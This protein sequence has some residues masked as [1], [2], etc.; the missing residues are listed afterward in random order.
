MQDFNLS[1]WRQ[2]KIRNDKVITTSGTV[3]QASHACAGQHTTAMTAHCNCSAA[4]LQHGLSAS[5]YYGNLIKQI[6]SKPLEDT[7]Q[8][9]H[10]QVLQHVVAAIA[11]DIGGGPT[12]PSVCHSCTRMLQC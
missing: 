4:G 11:G 9:L 6:L 3:P 8:P 10:L 2:V 5:Q 12:A 7:A 1:V